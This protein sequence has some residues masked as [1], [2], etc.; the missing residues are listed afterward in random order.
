MTDSAAAAAPDR[1]SGLASALWA[2]L[3]P[4]EGRLFMALHIAFLCA[5]TAVV[6]MAIRMPEAL[7]AC[8]LV[9]FAYKDN[10]GEGIAIGFGLIVAATLAIGVGVLLLTVLADAPAP[11]FATILLLTFGGMFLWRASRMGPASYALAFILAFVLMLA[12]TTPSPELL[13]RALTWL[14]VVVIV[15]MTLL[16]VSNILFGRSPLT[17]ARR[18]IAERLETA[19]RVLE[20]HDADPA[21]L[22]EDGDAEALGYVRMARL[23]GELRGPEA[24]DRLRAELD[25]SHRVLRAAAAEATAEAM[26][27]RDGGRWAADLRALAEGAAVAAERSPSGPLAEAVAALVAARDPVRAPRPPA[28]AAEPFFRPDA[29]TNPAYVRF[30]L[31]VVLA[32]AITY[33]L[34]L[35]IDL[36]DI[37]TAMVTCFFVALGT[38][39]EVFHKSSLRLAGCLIG[40]LMGGLATYLIVPSLTDV[41]HLF[42]LIAAGGFVAGWVALGTWRT[43]YLGWQMALA[44]FICVLPGSPLSFG[45][46]TDLADAGY[47]IL[48]ILLGVSVMGAVFALIWPESAEDALARETAAALRAGADA[49]RGQDRLTAAHVHLGAA[50]Q[51]GE[52]MAF[53][54]LGARRFGARR[55]AMLDRLAAA[56]TLVTMIPVLARR[57]DAAMLAEA[58]AAAAEGAAA[59]TAGT[60]EDSLGARAARLLRPFAQPEFAA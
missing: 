24:A 45:P 16:V 28:K 17:L 31:K 38:G 58:M 52:V 60:P 55:R 53:E 11:R 13:V 34:V 48:G 37:H 44:F 57:P 26:S 51:A 10:A 12:D 41:G 56:R 1:E 33:V 30:S 42:A 54:R 18:V 49:L 47:R 22:L 2:E 19:A 6:G 23:M 32:V 7:L 25:A 59:R 35:A 46:N 9:F 39:G 8:Y 27:A 14:W 40:T 5:A 29:F 21:R 43:Q 36:F 4:Y 15:P 50:R 3:R 20:A